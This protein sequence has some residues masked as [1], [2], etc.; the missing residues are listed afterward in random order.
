MTKRSVFFASCAPG[1]EP[2]LHSEAQELKLAKVERQ[3]GGIYFEGDLVDMWR[4]NLWLRTAVRIFMRVG[5]FHASDAAQL[6][7]GASEVDWSRF[8]SPEGSLVV[9]SQSRESE[10]FHTHFIQQRVKDAVVDQFRK[11]TGVRPTVDV[12][13]PDL[14]IHAHLYNDRV[15]LSVD[16]SGGSLH[17]RGWRQYQGIA[18]IA[19]TLAAAIVLMS[20]WDCRSP[21]IDPFCGSGTLAIEAALIA[22]KVPPGSFRTFGFESWPGHDA[23]SYSRFKSAEIERQSWPRKLQIRASDSDAKQVEGAKQNAEAA[24]FG[25][26][27]RFDVLDALEFEAKPGWNAFIVTNPPYGLRVGDEEQLVPLYR[28]FGQRLFESCSGYR[29]AMILGNPK[30]RRALGLPEGEQKPVQNGTI[31]CEFFRLTLGD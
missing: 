4:A 20:D 15:T 12:D 16:T 25:D 23:A 1:L 11:A 7:K 3:V 27:I 18:P 5:R 6:Y 26:R 17:K 14:R 21:F 8:V 19:E 29:L 24:G 30:L 31:P 10:L 13:D 22:A 2:V 28:D 9:D